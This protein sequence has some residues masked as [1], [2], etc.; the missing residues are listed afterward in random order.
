M[1]ATNNEHRLACRFANC[2][3][4]SIKA[5]NGTGREWQM[6][7]TMQSKRYTTRLKEIPE[8]SDRIEQ[9]FTTD[10]SLEKQLRMN[11]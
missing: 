6:L 11:L 9:L 1:L 7:S 10:T 8:V 3:S 2:V 4:A 5:S